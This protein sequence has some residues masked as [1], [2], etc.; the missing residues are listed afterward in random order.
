MGALLV[1]KSRASTMVDE[2]GGGFTN[3]GVLLLLVCKSR[4]ST[5]VD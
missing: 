3:E 2:W 5:M 1:C 4:A